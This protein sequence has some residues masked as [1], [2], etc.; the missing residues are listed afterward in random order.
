MNARPPMRSSTSDPNTNNAKRLN[1]RWSGPPC[2]NMYVTKTHGRANASRGSKPNRCTNHG[3]VKIVSCKRNTRRLA[4]NSR[5]THGVMPNT[6]CEPIMS[7]LSPDAPPI[8]PPLR[9]GADA[10]AHLSVLEPGSPGRLGEQAHLRHSRQTVGLEAENVALGS[11]PKVNSR[12]P[13]EFEGTVGGY[14]QFLQLS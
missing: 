12:I 9:A 10:L 14:R 7:C 3:P 4:T 13:P 2:R 11:H 8:V 1:A 5:R 6:R